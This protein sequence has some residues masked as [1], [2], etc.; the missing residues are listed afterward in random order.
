MKE[1]LKAYLD[2][3]RLHFFFVWPTLFC[4]GLVLS[5]HVY[6]GFSWLLTLK[7]VLISFI[8]FEAG[9][10]LNDIVDR[11]LDKKDVEFDKL[12]RY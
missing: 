11:E 12:T 10:V 8:G 5:F 2:L 7:A 3:T 9:F 4:S 1:T 6:G